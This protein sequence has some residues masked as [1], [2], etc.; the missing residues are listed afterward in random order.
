MERRTFVIG[1]VAGGIG[2]VEY[3]FVNGWMSKLSAR[4]GLSVK[5]FEQHGQQAMQISVV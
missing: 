5:A 2:L 3:A 1:A 4:P